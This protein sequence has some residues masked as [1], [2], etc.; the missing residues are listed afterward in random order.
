LG[1]LKQQLRTI[2]DFY[3]TFGDRQNL[4]ALKSSKFYKMMS[5]AGILNSTLT[6]TRLDLLFC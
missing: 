4:N 3:T 6:T 5:D 2:F 1:T